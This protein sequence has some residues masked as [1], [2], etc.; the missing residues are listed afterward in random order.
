MPKHIKQTVIWQN[1]SV[2]P[3]LRSNQPIKM[4]PGLSWGGGSIQ[5]ATIRSGMT[6]AGHTCVVA[7]ADAVRVRLLKTGSVI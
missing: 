2:R 6:L 7:V 5:I 4:Y 3:W 1:G